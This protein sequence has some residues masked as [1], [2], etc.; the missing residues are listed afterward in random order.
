M[1]QINY[2]IFK[3]LILEID[4]LKLSQNHFICWDEEKNEDNVIGNFFNRLLI[5]IFLV[6]KLI[7]FKIYI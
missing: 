1:K 5:S 3:L 7:S 2:K 6:V 4:H